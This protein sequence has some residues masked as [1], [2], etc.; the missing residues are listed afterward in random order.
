MSNTV[1]ECDYSVDKLTYTRANW[2]R[3]GR[4]CGWKWIVVITLALHHQGWGLIPG[5]VLHVCYL[6]GGFFWIL[7]FPT[8]VQNL[9]W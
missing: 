4:G 5:S 2:W 8:P 7:W 9:E 3:L 6:Q 1:S